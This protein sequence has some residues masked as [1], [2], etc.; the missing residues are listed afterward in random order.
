VRAAASVTDEPVAR[1]AG[2]EPPSRARSPVGDRWAV[3]VGISEYADDRLTLR[4]AHR[5]AQALYEFLLTP[6][7]GAF[8]AERIRLLLD[9][10]A[11]RDGL[12]KAFRS[13]LAQTTE[14]DLV[15]IYIAC[16]GMPDAAAIGQPLYVL[17]HDANLDDV[18]ATSLP[19][20]ELAWCLRNYVRAQRVVILADT[21]HSEGMSTGTRGLDLAAAELNRYLDELST[22][23]PGIAYLTSAREDQRSYE[24]EKWGDGHGAFTWCLL[25][26]MRGAADGYGGRPKDGVVSLGELADYVR[27][28][29]FKET[30]RRQEPILGAGRYDVELPLAVAGGLD[31]EQH[32]ALGRALMEVGWLLDDPAPFL[33]AARE[34]STAI[35]LAALTGAIVAPPYA[36]AGEALL[37]A[38]QAEQAA[39][40]L[41]KASERLGD[42]LA[43]EAWLH[44]GLAHAERGDPALASS[45]LTEFAKRAPDAPEARWAKSYSRWLRDT[46]GGVTRALV[47]CVGTYELQNLPPLPGPANDLELVTGLLE[48][49]GVE[50]RN[51][52]VLV[53]RFATRDAIVEALRKLATASTRRDTL[54]FYFSGHG[55]DRPD[56]P[57]LITH[58]AP[59]RVRANGIGDVELP[60][61][62]QAAPARARLVILD[63]HGS[64]GFNAAIE[65]DSVATA[66][67]A[68]EPGAM[69]YE[70][71]ASGRPQGA[72][73]SAL[74][75]T[76]KAAP[77]PKDLTYAELIAGTT[78]RLRGRV[79]QVPVLLGDP[80]APVLQGV[81][82][83]RDLWR[84]ARVRGGASPL[85]SRTVRAC[86]KKPWVQ[87]RRLLARR[88][89]A[90][91]QFGEALEILQEIAA[92]EN[93]A[94]TWLELAEVAA[95]AGR[96][97]NALKALTGLRALPE[98]QRWG[99]ETT[100]AARA[101]RALRD[102]RPRALL[103]GIGADA[104]RRTRSAPRAGRALTAMQAFLRKQGFAEGD[105]TV[106][107]ER[108]ATRRN[109]LSGLSRLAKAARDELAVFYF[110]GNGSALA[111]GPALLPFDAG[112]D[113]VEPLTVAELAA[114]ADGANNLVTVIDLRYI[115]DGSGA[116]YR[117]PALT[118][119]VGVGRDIKLPLRSGDA[120]GAPSIGAVTLIQATPGERS[121]DGSAGE[122]PSPARHTVGALTDALIDATVGIEPAW[123]TYES[124]A[125][126]A[127][128]R[129]GVPVAALGE[130]VAEPLLRHRTRHR[131]ALRELAAVAAA[132]AGTAI[133]LT[134]RQA[135]RSE[136]RKEQ[137]PVTYLELGLAFAVAGNAAEAVRFLRTARN[138]YDD[139]S[140]REEQ[141]RRDPQV[142]LWHRE[143]R[144]HLGRL[145]HEHGQSADELNEAVASLRQAHDQAPE[146]LRIT[147]HLGLA[148]QAL[149]ERQSI[150][151]AAEL[152]Q[153][154]LAAGA[155]LGRES[156]VR[157]FLD[158]R[159]AP[160]PAR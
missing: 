63:T 71:T 36:L 155:P 122:R 80:S 53:D 95:A 31:V 98:A 143:S 10:A 11:T 88:F 139:P 119:S 118:G 4:Y 156:E 16:H 49:L 144:Y 83:A 23:K 24:D 34:A 102:A 70:D 126:A 134:K 138:L 40:L 124:W 43:V 100:P 117:A 75:E 35:E 69:A 48:H 150:V 84:L 123:L 2:E 25:E 142:D 151:E 145:L 56:L 39:E 113:G 93:D 94:G 19:M 73:T 17:T 146:D 103:V 154:Y 104:R 68:S 7:G 59:G 130:A 158:Q 135:A 131:A 37:A 125:S 87:G 9:R 129:A 65:E 96:F 32:F 92:T 112:E 60:S 66:I 26:G 115:D 108:D 90:G 120:V 15:L 61:L 76:W 58:D 111:G 140:I 91:E 54:I 62:L 52:M 79:Q 22:T 50:S 136:E 28:R 74:V 42:D 141:A 5:D 64:R 105:L 160:E 101:V 27:D 6:A 121:D 157:A 14:D 110:V 46:D 137:A 51:V 159:A 12:T 8:A 78:E 45:L 21:C 13:F 109:I 82:P 86:E 20:D 97:D 127:S 44:R 107:S 85:P 132:P 148:I 116:G 18:G 57:Y 3:L 89:A 153:T 152:L 72:L 29:V 147:L 67:V 149:V 106:L 133:E 55:A 38:N 114:L 99:A 81:F 30:G 1:D 33:C 47:V 128:G 77:K 41:D